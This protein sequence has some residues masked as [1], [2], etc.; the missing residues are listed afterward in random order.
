MPLEDTRFCNK[1]QGRRKFDGEMSDDLRT[2]GAEFILSGGDL[3]RFC[4][5]INYNR[6][7]EAEK[8]RDRLA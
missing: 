7:Y 1:L 8:A 6:T 4:A 5:N 3:F 2:A